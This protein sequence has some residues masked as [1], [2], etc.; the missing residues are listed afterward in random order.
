[1]IQR[2][3]AVLRVFYSLNWKRLLI[4]IMVSI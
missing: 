4:D 3:A 1:M 2:S